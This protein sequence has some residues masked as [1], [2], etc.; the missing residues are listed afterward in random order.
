MAKI[1]WKKSNGNK[2]ETNDEKATVDYCESLNW[3]RIGGEDK[4]KPKKKKDK[5]PE[6]D[7]D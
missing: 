3:E 7:K 1:T 4:P 5:A 6:E 2:M